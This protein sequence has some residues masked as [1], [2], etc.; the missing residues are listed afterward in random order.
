M[1][2]NAVLTVFILGVVLTIIA[3][4]FAESNPSGAFISSLIAIILFTYSAYAAN[5]IEVYSY[6]LTK[7]IVVRD[8]G[9]VM[10]SLGGMIINAVLIGFTT[11][12][13]GVR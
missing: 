3:M 5:M 6:D 9:L 7:T 4:F 11:T 13:Y 10:L 12:S 2:V 1:L 8:A